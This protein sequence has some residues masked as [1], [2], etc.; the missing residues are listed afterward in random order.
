MGDTISVRTEPM[1]QKDGTQDEA[2]KLVVPKLTFKAIREY[3]QNHN[4][5]FN[6]EVDDHKKERRQHTKKYKPGKKVKFKSRNREKKKV[7]PMMEAV[8][9][10]QA[11]L[12]MIHPRLFHFSSLLFS[13][14]SNPISIYKPTY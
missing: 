10:K 12:L 14:F 8:S 5:I 6:K 2:S 13:F 7:H 1:T 11:H 4:P 9:G 3:Q